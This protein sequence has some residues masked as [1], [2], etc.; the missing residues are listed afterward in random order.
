MNEKLLTQGAAAFAVGVAWILALARSGEPPVAGTGAPRADD[1]LADLGAHVEAG[2][3]HV[4]AAEFAE[5][6]LAGRVAVFD[7]QT[8]EEFARLRLPGATNWT[9]GTLLAPE[10]RAALDAARAGGQEVVLVSRG[11]THA[12]QAWMALAARGQAQG[13]RVLADGLAGFA[14]EVLMPASL[15][16]PAA[17]PLASA[18]AVRWHEL[19]QQVAGE[20]RAPAGSFATEPA[21]LETPGV[22]TTAWLARHYADVVVLD[23]R[24]KSADFT[25]GHLPG[26]WHLPASAL[27]ANRGGEHAVDEL[28]TVDELAVIHSQL[29]IGPDTMVVAYA[30]AKMHDA[31]HALMGLFR[32]GHRR[33]AL[34]DGG[35]ERWRAEDRPLEAGEPPTPRAT[36]SPYPLDRA[37]DSFIADL[38]AVVRAQR[39]GSASILDVRPVE[40]FRGEQSTEARPGHVPGALNR[41][42]ALDQQGAA[43]QPEAGLREA[44]RA[45]GIEPGVDVIVGCRTGH[46]AAFTWFTLRWLL[47]VDGVRWW[48]GSWQE[49]AAHPELPAATG[50]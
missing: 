4:A 6:L 25:A 21:K 2:L 19:R 17:A 50:A 14:S 33:L 12:A 40:Q 3:D 42:M 22:V 37:D 32:L 31:A 7:L 18:D 38:D 46:Q 28:R 43:W 8:P 20:A 35:V 11:M 10:G 39:D 27:R 1:A 47:G 15:R 41:P 16:D 34:L 26:A 48:D 49:W 24:G 9:L 36:A 44:Y 45:L 29:G 30:D 5:L 13:V 23:G